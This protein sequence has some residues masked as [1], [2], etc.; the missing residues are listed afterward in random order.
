MESSQIAKL[1]AEEYFA[2][3]AIVENYNDQSLVIKGWSVTVGIAA[4]IA[5]YSQPLSE[6]A[7]RV[8]VFV[9]ALATLPFY[10]TDAL[11]KTYQDAYAVR[12]TAIEAQ[13]RG[14][15]NVDFGLPQSWSDVGLLQ[16]W[17]DWENA[18]DSYSLQSI[19]NYLGALINPSV[20]M[21]HVFVLIVGIVLAAK[22]PP[23][24]MRRY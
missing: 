20:F 6:G 2:L 3:L 1:L 24:Q 9:A 8:G 4:L 16:S 19:M 17:S 22:F 7:G 23:S 12:I 5:A 18:Y 13:Y 21:P 10:L 15:F 11:W 14:P